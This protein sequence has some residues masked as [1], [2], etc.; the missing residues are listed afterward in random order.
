MIDL[1]WAAIGAST[2]AVLGA[3][4]FLYK[5]GIKNRV[6]TSLKIHRIDLSQEI[7]ETTEKRIG[8]L[9]ATVAQIDERTKVI[10]TLLKKD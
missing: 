4:G 7:R 5:F 3:V 8:V 10:L 2:M 6:D 9:A 1:S